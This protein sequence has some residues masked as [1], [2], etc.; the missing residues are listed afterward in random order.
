MR[1]LII[2]EVC[3]H[4]STGKICADIAD[5]Y[6]SNGWEVKIAYGRDGYVPKQYQ[7]YAIR[8]GN[9]FNVRVAA[10]QVRLFDNAGFANRNVTKKFVMRRIW[11]VRVHTFVKLY[12]SIMTILRPIPSLNLKSW[13][14]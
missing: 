10:L 4:T 2:N 7:K 6:S 14:I 11:E 1:L 12:L 13:K 5:R 9:D 8:I 3:G